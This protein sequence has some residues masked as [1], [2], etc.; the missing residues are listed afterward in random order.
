MVIEEAAGVLKFRRRRERGER[1]LEASEQNLL[2]LRTCYR[3]VRRQLRPLE[4]QAEAARRH[5]GTRRRVAG[6]PL[7]LAGREL[8]LAR[9][10]AQSVPSD[11]RRVAGRRKSRSA[12][13][14]RASTNW[15]STDRRSPTYRPGTGPTVSGAAD[16]CSNASEG[17]RRGRGKPPHRGR[18]RS[19]RSRRRTSS[20]RSKPSPRACKRTCRGR[21][22]CSRA[23]ARTRDAR[24]A[25]GRVTARRGEL[26]RPPR[27]RTPRPPR[28]GT[29]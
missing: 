22:G 1:R 29:V 16:A 27:A 12:T 7:H 28:S 5:D 4:R 20:P 10:A 14:W 15:A 21:G 23:P 25:R 24:E 13:S 11:P 9:P 26:P 17:W 3:E 19:P 2:R 8:E 18:F 6:A